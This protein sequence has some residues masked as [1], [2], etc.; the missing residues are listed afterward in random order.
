MDPITGMLIMAGANAAMGGMK[1]AQARKQRKME[2]EMR[3]AEIEASPWTGKQATTQISTA[4]P[5]LWADMLGGAVSGLGQAQALQQAGLFK[6][7]EPQG[8]VAPQ[9]LAP[10]EYFMQSQ[11]QTMTWNRMI[12]GQPTLMGRKYGS[13]F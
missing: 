4:S 7:A 1:S 10:E 9:E 2:A 3:A 5:S 6:S 13:S 12:P 8:M 11:P